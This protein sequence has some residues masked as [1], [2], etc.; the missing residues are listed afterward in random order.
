[1][2]SIIEVN[3]LLC[4][5]CDLCVEVCE[6][7]VLYMDDFSGLCRVRHEEKCDRNGACL[8]VCA[9]GAIKIN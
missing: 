7:G 3:P 4:T 9:P 2:G 5:G 8:K 1:M 6:K